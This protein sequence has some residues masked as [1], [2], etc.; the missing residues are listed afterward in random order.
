MDDVDLLVVAICLQDQER[1]EKQPLILEFDYS[2]FDQIL[3]VPRK[4]AQEDTQSTYRDHLESK[5]LMLGL[6]LQLIPQ[7]LLADEH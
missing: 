5:Q 7:T 3:N 4:H 6:F 1:L 2:I